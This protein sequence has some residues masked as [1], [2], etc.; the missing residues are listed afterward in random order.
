MAPETA[1]NCLLSPETPALTAG[2]RSQ[3]RFPFCQ[4]YFLINQKNLIFLWLQVI[5]FF[6]KALY[7]YSRKRGKKRKLELHQGELPVTDV[8]Y[9]PPFFF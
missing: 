9:S 3:Q 2:L 1:S 6:L 4:I 5:F 7:N 8:F